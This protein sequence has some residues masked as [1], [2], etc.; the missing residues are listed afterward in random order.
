M[1]APPPTLTLEEAKGA[2]K[3]CSKSAVRGVVSLHA[4]RT[5]P[6]VAAAL[7]DAISAFEQPENV[8]RIKDAAAQVQPEQRAMAILPI[9]QQIQATVLA[10]HGFEGP[11]GVFQGIMAIKAHESD[12]EVKQGVQ[13]VTTG[14]MKHVM[15]A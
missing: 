1:A 10:R 7:R 11:T 5:F 12:P 3:S 6:A 14:Y 2:P 4:T 9:V 15:G 13:A 8:Q